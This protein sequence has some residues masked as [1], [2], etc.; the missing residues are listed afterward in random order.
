MGVAQKAMFSISDRLAKF[1][2]ISGASMEHNAIANQNKLFFLQIRQKRPL[3][4]LANKYLPLQEVSSLQIFPF[5][6][7]RY[8]TETFALN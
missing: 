7:M 8:I 6:R 3:T 2:G 5:S 1:F 4:I